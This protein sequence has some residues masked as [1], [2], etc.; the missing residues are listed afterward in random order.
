MYIYI[1]YFVSLFISSLFLINSK[2]NFFSLYVN[3][4]LIYLTQTQHSILS[5][6][7]FF[8]LFLYIKL[9]SYIYTLKNNNSKKKY[10]INNNNNSER[11]KNKCKLK[12]LVYKL[13]NKKK[14]RKANSRRHHR[15]LNYFE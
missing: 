3:Y 2:N 15:Y 7:F 9:K 1:P 8:V 4:S 12:S 10:I 14:K 5:I 6:S 11:N 13:I